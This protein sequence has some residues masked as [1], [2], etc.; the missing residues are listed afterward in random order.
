V[1]TLALGSA[2]AIQ[3]Q[4]GASAEAACTR[5]TTD[6][7]RAGDEIVLLPIDDLVTKA[8]LQDAIGRWRRCDGYATAFPRFVIGDGHGRRVKVRLEN[9][10]PGAGHCGLFSGEVITLHRLARVDNAIVRCPSLA[11][12]LAH[13][14]GH[15][16]GLRDI[17]RVQGCPSFIMSGIVEAS[18]TLQRVA[19]AE[20]N[21]VDRR[22][23]TSVEER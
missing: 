10:V 4:D 22:W 15:V 19:K 23:R 20:C 7:I 6:Q 17:E 1:L 13:E 21:A 2:R 11:R 9:G 8:L 3:T 12:V 16:L 18:P 5:L 14:L